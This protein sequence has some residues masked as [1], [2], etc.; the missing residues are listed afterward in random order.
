MTQTRTSLKQQLKRWQ[1]IISNWKRANDEGKDTIGMMDDNL[2]TQQH[3]YNLTQND[4]N[5]THTDKYQL[6][7]L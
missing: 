4:N 1:S 7:N 2:D 6:Y 5:H 3:T